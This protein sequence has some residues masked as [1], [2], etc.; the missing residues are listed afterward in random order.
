MIQDIHF[1]PSVISKCCH[2]M[3]SKNWILHQK[4]IQMEWEHPVLLG[5]IVDNIRLKNKT[6]QKKKQS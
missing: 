2:L 1:M 3:S 5:C 6:K 4:T